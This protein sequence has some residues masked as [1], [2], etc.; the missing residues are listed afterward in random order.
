ML[1]SHEGQSFA[2]IKAEYEA[3]EK[4]FRQEMKDKALASRREAMAAQ[5][6]DDEK[7]QLELTTNNQPSALQPSQP[8][9]ATKRSMPAMAMIGPGD[10]PGATFSPRSLAFAEANPK[11]ESAF[12]S[13]AL[14]LR[15]SGGSGM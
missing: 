7:R 2:T 12:D 9:N 13:L 5:K 14:A 6:A 15:T 1:P 4:Q 3:A 11:N 8:V 10:G